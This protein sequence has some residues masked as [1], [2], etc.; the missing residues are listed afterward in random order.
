[1][2]LLF[3]LFYRIIADPCY[4]KINAEFCTVLHKFF[5]EILHEF[6]HES[7]H[8]SHDSKFHCHTSLNRPPMVAHLLSSF[9]RI[10][11]IT[12]QAGGE[13]RHQGSC[14]RISLSHSDFGTPRRLVIILVVVKGRNPHHQQ[15]AA[16][17]AG[18][19]ESH[20]HTQFS[21]G[22]SRSS[23]LRWSALSVEYDWS[24]TFCR[25]SWNCLCHTK[26]AAL[27]VLLFS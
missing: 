5:W 3:I 7:L 25:Q 11:D 19:R 23:D 1:M 9:A 18:Y 26:G 16:S 6:L 13:R 24:R 14:C 22:P 27:Q 20:C 4:K 2:I 15:A 21:G 17:R 12:W 10:L 8:E